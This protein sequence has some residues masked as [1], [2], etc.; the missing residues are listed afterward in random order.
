MLHIIKWV[1]NKGKKGSSC[2]NRLNG[3]RKHPPYTCLH[4]LYQFIHIG[5]R[6]DVNIHR[7]LAGKTVSTLAFLQ[8]VLNT[9]LIASIR[10]LL[11]F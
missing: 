6:V 2:V 9:Q 5:L 1:N 7:T 10:D 4:P 11:P 3:G 8:V